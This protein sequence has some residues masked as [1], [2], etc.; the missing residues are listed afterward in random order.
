MYIKLSYSNFIASKNY[1]GGFQSADPSFTISLCDLTVIPNYFFFFF[2]NLVV[3]LLQKK[4]L[5]KY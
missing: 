5:N 1:N 3:L 2:S 4:F